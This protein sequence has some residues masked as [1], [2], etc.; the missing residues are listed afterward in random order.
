M[1]STDSSAPSRT[2]STRHHRCDDAFLGLL[3]EDFGIDA[4][5]PHRAFMGVPPAAKKEAIAL[6]EWAIR[7]AGGDAERAGDAL[8][9]WA[10]KHGRGGYGR[11][12]GDAPPN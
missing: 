3:E 1:A 7:S 9:A 11:R 6:C 12:L 10:E 2:R 4:Y 8:R 5:S